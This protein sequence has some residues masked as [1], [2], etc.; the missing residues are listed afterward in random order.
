[1]KFTALAALILTLV[2]VTARAEVPRVVADIAP[3]HS[4][5]ARVMK[6]AGAPDLLMPAGTS[7]HD[8]ALKPSTALALAQADLIFWIGPELT[9]WLKRAVSSLGSEARSVA[10]LSNGQIETLAR[11]EDAAFKT[12]GHDH[13]HDHS[14]DHGAPDPHLWLDPRNGS[15]MLGIIA[16]ALSE[17]DPVN[18]ALYASNAADAMGELQSL[19]GEISE[20]LSPLQ[21]RGFLVFHDAYHY[22]EDRFALKAAGAVAPSD[23]AQ[24]G[25][26][27]VASLRKM[28]R[29]G[30]VVC[31]FSEPQLDA[32]ALR[33]VAADAGLKA[34]VL[35]PLGIGVTPGPAL[36]PQVLRGLA[37]AMRDCLG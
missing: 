31:V 30:G 16:A 36:Y 19:E 27:R 4:L 35:D 3:V 5:V 6:G 17:A 37:V 32:R 24:P 1:M 10:F 14:H 26:A 28:V 23:G 2:G 11:R 29:E 34:G 13:D 8:H 20:M 15:E 7:P 9:P 12:D 22:F 21:D 33:L 25:P 18:A